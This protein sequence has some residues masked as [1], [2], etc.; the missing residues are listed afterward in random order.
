VL[1][2][3]VPI[4]M[5]HQISPRP[6]PAFRKYT[7]TPAAFAAQMRWLAAAGYATVTPDQLADAR[8]GR[9]G[10]PRKPVMVTFDDG[11]RECVEHALPVLHGHGFAGVFYLV[12]GLVGAT[13][14]W[15]RPVIGDEFPMA[16]WDAVREVERAGSV[17]GAHSWSHPRLAE[18]PA[19]AWRRELLD[20]RLLLEDRLGH[21]VDHLAY[22][23]GSWN[24]DVRETAARAGYR[25]ACSVRIGLSGPGDDPL[26]LHRVPVNG[27]DGLVDFVCRL[28]TARTLRETVGRA[29]RRLAP[30]RRRAAA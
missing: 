11:F 4:L 2:G 14:R 27:T 20:A 6:H 13:S 25:S 16:N 24:E 17:C 10:L 3:R 19:A 15:L 29:V 30:G 21:R 12:A 1:S 9:G 22:P 5:Y 28:R 8:A 23:H 7:V 18:V 26:A